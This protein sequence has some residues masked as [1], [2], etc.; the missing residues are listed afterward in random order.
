MINHTVFLSMTLALSLSPTDH[1][2]LFL[3]KKALDIYRLT[4]NHLTAAI[5]KND[6]KMTFLIIIKNGNKDGNLF[7]S[8]NLHVHQYGKR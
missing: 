3:P 4:I 6:D 2:D 8:G 1:S 7:D 5:S